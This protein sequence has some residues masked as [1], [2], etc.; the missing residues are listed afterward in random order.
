MLGMIQTEFN[1]NIEE[2]SWLTGSW[3]LGAMVG[4]LLFGWIGDRYG[5]KKTFIIT[6]LWYSICT[7]IT[8]CS[9]N[10]YFFF[11]FRALTSIGVAGEYSAVT[12]SIAEFVPSEHR[13]KLSI[14]IQGT[15]G[16]GALLA[17]AV[18]IPLVKYLPPNYA[19]RVGCSLGA[20]AGLITLF[21]RRRLPES[22]RFS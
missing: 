14:L 2:A 12:A 17:N 6:I 7:V 16:I 1:M 4:S 5:R 13:G 21:A 3:L 8:A 9:P 19:W 22:P 20:L 11:I 18:D 15:W 10:K